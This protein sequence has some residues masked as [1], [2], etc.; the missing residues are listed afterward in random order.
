[1]LSSLGRSSGHRPGAQ[2]DVGASLE[3]KALRCDCLNQDYLRVDSAPT[4]VNRDGITVGINPAFSKIRAHLFSSSCMSF[5]VVKPTQRHPGH[6][7]ARQALHAAVRVDLW[8]LRRTQ[9]TSTWTRAMRAA[10]CWCVRLL[11]VTS[12]TKSTICFMT[13]PARRSCICLRRLRRLLGPLGAMMGPSS[14]WKKVFGSPARRVAP[15]LRKCLAPVT[16]WDVF[17]PTSSFDVAWTCGVCCCSGPVLLPS[18]RFVCVFGLER[19]RSL[20]LS[21]CSASAVSIIDPQPPCSIK[22]HSRGALRKETI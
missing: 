2:Q 16:K 8:V 9:R 6:Q 15:S 19:F 22:V 4:L 12:F 5:D 7:S 21:S 20:R 18:S 17:V 11:R 13:H 3:L 1:M 14:E 10:R